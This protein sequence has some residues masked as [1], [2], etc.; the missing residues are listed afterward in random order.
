VASLPKG[1][2]VIGARGSP[3]VGQTPVDVPGRQAEPL[4]V[5]PVEVVQPLEVVAEPSKSEP[6]CTSP[7]SSPSEAGQFDVGRIVSG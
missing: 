6:D 2:Y 7:E 4:V 3:A 1:G 5:Q